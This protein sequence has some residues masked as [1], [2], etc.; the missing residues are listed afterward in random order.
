MSQYHDLFSICT[1]ILIS[2]YEIILFERHA[3][4][5]TRALTGVLLIEFNE[6]CTVTGNVTL[7]PASD[8]LTWRMSSSNK[9][10]THEV[11]D[12]LMF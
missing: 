4:T 6:L 7:S 10:S 11:Y 8:Q 3:L 9:F 1:D 12:W 2:V 5:F